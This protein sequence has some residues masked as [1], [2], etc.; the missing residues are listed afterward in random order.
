MAEAPDTSILPNPVNSQEPQKYQE[1]LAAGFWKMNI[2]GSKPID[3]PAIQR[4]LMEVTSQPAMSP[5]E[6]QR[7]CATL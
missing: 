7:V 1:D 5:E 4:F 3:V 2:G 6:T